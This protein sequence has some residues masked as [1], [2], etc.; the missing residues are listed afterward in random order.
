MDGEEGAT[1]IKANASGINKRISRATKIFDASMWRFIIVQATYQILVILSLMYLGIFFLVD[2]PYNLILTDIRDK[3]TSKPTD[4]MTVNTIVFTTYFLMNMVNQFSV[5]SLNNSNLKNIFNNWIFWIV[6]L[7]EMTITH[8]MLYLGESNYGNAIL[9]VTKISANQY[10]ICWGL[11]LTS[12][13]L[14]ILSQ[15]IPEQKF[16]KFLNY[17]DLEP[18]IPK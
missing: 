5:R 10:M 2:E 4:K 15:K 12:L 11:A 8:G 9:G 1:T 18:Q 13:P 3:A 6:V 16:E 14:A 7:V 17:F